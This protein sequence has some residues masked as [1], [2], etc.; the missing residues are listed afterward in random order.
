MIIPNQQQFTVNFAR[1]NFNKIIEY[2]EKEAVI[3]TKNEQKFLI[4]NQ[5]NL[6][7]WLE[8]FVILQN[9]EIL[10]DIKVAREEY[11]REECLEMDDIFN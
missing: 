10:N 7:S 2:A 11:E 4:I 6:E 5:D 8:T 9:E 3:L 1:E